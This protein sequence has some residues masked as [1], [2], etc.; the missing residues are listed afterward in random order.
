MKGI[1]QTYI[2]PVFDRTDVP[3]LH[4]NKIEVT[5][6]TTF[7][8]CTYKAE[9]GSWARISKE[10]YL[11]DHAKHK[12]YTILRCS[13]LPFSPQQRDFRFGE[14]V[15]IVFCFPSI[16]SATKLDFIEDSDEE[17]FNIYG[18]DVKK[19]NAESYKETDYNH[20]TNMLSMYHDVGNISVAIQYA[21]KRVD[22][23]IYVYGSKSETYIASLS[24]LSILYW[25]AQ[26]YDNAESILSEVLDYVKELIYS[27]ASHLTN[28]QKKQMWY[29]YRNVFYLYRD[30][31]NRS[32]RDGT[33]LSKLY[34]YILFSKRLSLD[35]ETRREEGLA[36]LGITWKD[37]Q[38]KLS[39]NDIAIEFISTVSERTEEMQ[40]CVYHALIIDRDCQCPQMITLVDERDLQNERDST[41]GNLIWG[42]IL[43]KYKNV[44]NIYFSPDGVWN[45]FPIEYFSVDNIGYLFDKCNMYRLSSTKELVASHKKLNVENAVLYGGLDYWSEEIPT[46]TMIDN[47]TYALFRGIEERGGF[48]P[49]YGTLS[50]I[51]DIKDI[52]E[53][54]NI[55][56]FAYSGK[57]G[58]EDSFKKL[59]GK[60]VGIIHFATHGMYVNTDDWEQ[61]K[62]ENNF[63][64]E[65]YSALDDISLTH[66]LLVM[67]GRNEYVRH[68]M[69]AY[70]NNE[71]ILTAKEVSQIDLTGLELVVLSA[72]ET[73]L[74]DINVTDGVFGLQRGFKKAGAKT[75]LMSLNKVDDEA[76]KVLMTEFYKNLMNGESK[77]QSFKKAQKYLREFDNG[78]YLDPKYWQYF[79]MLDGLD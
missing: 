1:A 44:K 75:I 72:C 33:K 10:T 54:R 49:L 62:N 66:S 73:A 53:K 6:D 7:V 22:A 25:K 67:S 31:V 32:D 56:T 41:L 36:Q 58:T 27:G 57:N 65:E 51:N 38:C 69:E 12:K 68:D 2:E 77:L 46:L 19:H 60:N 63:E 3:S 30:V 21:K 17:A 18:I 39:D 29:K 52:L 35:I 5:K 61:K 34:D 40:Y 70:E 28:A 64:L 76:T 43:S 47:N 50:E 55:K 42:P 23:A 4:I 26:D 14:S 59:S 48:E 78:K 8:H 20:F 37:I 11:Y 74:G 79:I 9:V 71:G 15:Q 16:G 24:G 45:V 13:G